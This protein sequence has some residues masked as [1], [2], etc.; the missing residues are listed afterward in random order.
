MKAGKYVPALASDWRVSEDGRTV[1]FVLRED[2]LWH[3]GEPFTAD[4]VAY[5]YGLMQDDDFSG[6]FST[7]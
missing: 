6:R 7:A 3:D 4:D 1:R 5:T 2:V